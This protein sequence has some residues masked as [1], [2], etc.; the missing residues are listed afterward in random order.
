VA[1]LRSDAV[2]L[3]R[4][5]HRNRR[6]LAQYRR[7]RA[8]AQA[9]AAAPQAQAPDPAPPGQ[10]ADAPPARDTPAERVPDTAKPRSIWN[11]AM[12]KTMLD[13]LARDEETAGP[14]GLDG[15]GRPP[16][17]VQEPIPARA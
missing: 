8:A 9:E 4:E 6:A 1:R 3:S 12:I 7:D 10:A 5:A 17:P 13:E 15:S 14:E 11:P 2:R 16:P